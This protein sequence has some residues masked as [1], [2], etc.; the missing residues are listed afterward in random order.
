M[1]CF[2]TNSFLFAIAFFTAIIVPSTVARDCQSR[3]LALSP[4]GGGCTPV[5]GSDLCPATCQEGLDELATICS[6]DGATLFDEP[7]EEVTNL[8]SMLSLVD[9]ACR[10]TIQDEVLAQT[11]DTCQEWADVYIATPILFCND[12]VCSKF[13]KD[14]QDLFYLNCAADDEVIPDPETGEIVPVSELVTGVGILMGNSCREYEE[15][16]E[17]ERIGGVS[18]SS[19]SALSISIVAIIASL[20]VSSAII[21]L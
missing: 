3:Y 2:R 10:P 18:A 20:A 15:G 12:A 1:N 16:K 17:F 14:V 21:F 7:Y 9:E 5:E 8:L 6:V 13:C 11:G 4:F 19:P